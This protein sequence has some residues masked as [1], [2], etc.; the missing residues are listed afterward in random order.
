VFEKNRFWL[1]LP[2]ATFLT[3]CGSGDDAPAASARSI[4]PHYVGS[5]AC[6]DCH[7]EQHAEWAGSHHEL[8]MQPATAETVTGDFSGTSFDYAGTRYEFFTRGDKYLVRADDENGEIQEFEISHTFGTVPLQQY[9]VPFPDG[10]MQA[11]GVAWDT[12]PA[13]EGGQRW[14]HLYPDEAVTHTDELHWTG[15]NQNWN[16]MCADCHST[17]VR[18]NYD[19]T[20]HTYATQWDEVTVGCEACHG[21]ASA[22]VANAARG[23]YRE[24][25]LQATLDTPFR[26]VD[27]CARCHARR[28]ILAEGFA[29]G[30]A[31]LDFYRPALLE[32]GLYHA[33][34]Q[35]LDEVYVY[36]SFLQSKMHQRGVTCTDCHNPH[37]ARLENDGNATC[38]A[39]HQPQ[40][41]A[42]FPTLQ[43]KVYDHPDHHFHA[44]GSEGARCVNCHMPATVYM[45]VD[46]RRDHSFRVP[47]P[48]LAG[49]TGSP[50]ACNGCHTDRDAA[51]AAAEIRKRYPGPK[52]PHYGEVI[53]AGR[54]GDA[55]ALDRLAELAGDS[56]APGIARGTAAAL[57]QGYPGPTA[58]T[59]LEAA[60]QDPDPLVRLGGLQG[61][62]NLDIEQRWALANHLLDDDLLAVRADAGVTLV[63]MLERDLLQRDQERLLAAVDEYIDAQRLNA[64][65]P[66]ALT[67][68]GNVYS[69][70]ERPDDAEAAYRQALE[71]EPA[72]VPALVNLADLYRT[73]DREAEAAAVLE[74]ARDIAPG[75]AA[76]RHAFGLLLVREGR[77]GE[78][79]EELEVAVT[80]HPENP[81]YHFVYGIALNSTGRSDDA[82]AVLEAA[83]RAFPDNVDI[84]LALATIQRDR[85]NRAAAIEYVD[86]LLVSQPGNTQLRALRQQLADDGD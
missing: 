63:P 23:D 4:A 11:L 29:A 34:G 50:N 21:P 74:Q 67:N 13:E 51:W 80:L 60:L 61:L 79:L 57:L 76:V 49:Q 26:Q 58:A 8:A 56:A 45:V 18:K 81:R 16:Y 27:T 33:D 82:V 53:A 10:R 15:R 73:E 6:R 77:T 32:D 31:F 52:A 68:L 2:A 59:A 40:P 36:G 43:P 41:P 86:R 37:S 75:N 24:S 9:L 55:D 70:M 38:T 72:W 3:G 62:S 7:S 54:R 66:G 44:P 5:A 17:D 46:P 20:A 30:D 42:R 19:A 1:L 39:C 47:R 48:D 84:L 78:A 22:H 12:R 65:R 25:G 69:A 28:G 64:D 35:I 14:F 85:G 71:L 83:L